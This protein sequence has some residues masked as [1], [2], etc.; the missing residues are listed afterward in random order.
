MTTDDRI[1]IKELSQQVEN[2]ATLLQGTE[3]SE[4]TTLQE[5]RHL[6]YL[7]NHKP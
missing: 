6:L 1:L 7:L 4:S 5:I 3:A 2:L